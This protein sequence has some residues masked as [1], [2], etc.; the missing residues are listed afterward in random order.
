M[1]IKWPDM[2]IK[3]QIWISND[4]IRMPKWS[5]LNAKMI[6]HEC[7]IIRYECQ[8]FMIK[9]ECQILTYEK[10]TNVNEKMLYSCMQMAIPMTW[11][12]K[13]WLTKTCYRK[14]T[15]STNQSTIFPALHLQLLFSLNI[16]ND[17][18]LIHEWVNPL[19]KDMWK[20]QHRVY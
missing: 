5:H 18:V 2:N 13:T 11:L 10:C 16:Q 19:Y 8:N 1:N 7:Q 4:Q 9:Y 6:T 17:C 20:L 15:H 12:T 3:W 14:D